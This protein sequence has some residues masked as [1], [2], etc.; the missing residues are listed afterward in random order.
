MFR[1]ILAIGDCNTLGAKELKGNS[2]P[3]RVA[4]KIGS[5]V[6]NLGHTMAT[7]REGLGLLRDCLRQDCMVDA[8]CI[9]I[10]FGLADSSKTLRYSPYVLYYPENWC[11]KVL[12]A[13]TKKFKKT[14]RKAGMNVLL[15]ESN[16]VPIEEYEENLR[17]M[18]ELS[19]PRTV[20]LVDTIPTN[21]QD[22]NGE[23]VRYNKVLDKVCGDYETCIKI[24][25][26]EIFEKESHQFYM[27]RIH[28]S[29]A[30]Y[31]CIAAKIASRIRL[32]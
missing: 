20:F 24:D 29:N 21:N 17:K 22:R 8:D 6:I 25:L 12:R 2:Y 32:A 5:E 11:R 26:Y 27:D 10:Q 19:Q 14:C 1:K 16:T 3:E 18:V 30:G 4:D 7:T 13:L 23:L 9:F 15:G 28:C 31:E